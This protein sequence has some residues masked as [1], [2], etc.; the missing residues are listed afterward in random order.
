MQNS[1]GKKQKK[2]KQQIIMSGEVK[3]RK[4][5]ILA[6]ELREQIRC[7][8]L[9][10][11]D[12]LPTLAVVSLKS[13]MTSP[14]IIRAHS[15]LEREGLIYRQ[16]GNGTFVAAEAVRRLRG[17]PLAETIVVLTPFG[18]ALSR[19]DRA[20]GWANFTT[21]GILEEIHNKCRHAI[22]L[23]PD[24]VQNKDIEWLVAQQPLGVILDDNY[25]SDLDHLRF[26]TELFTQAAIPVAALG[27]MPFWTQCDRVESD[28]ARGAYELTRWL[29][30]QGRRRIL[31]LCPPGPHLDW[32]AKRLAGY[33]QAME[34]A[35]LA[36]LPPVTGP[37]LPL[38]ATT[39]ENFEQ[40]CRR[41]AAVLI[42]SLTGPTPCDALMAPS[43]GPAFYYAAACRLFGKQPNRDVLL[44]GY[45]N[46]W[47][48]SP[49]R[50]WEPVVPAVTVDKHNSKIGKA[51]VT[52]LN[53]RSAGACPAEPQLRV[54]A[55]D[56]VPTAAAAPSYFAPPA[57][58][59]QEKL[60]KAAAVSPVLV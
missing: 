1:S 21:A 29:L 7:G 59:P 31:P 9:K 56:L 32:V 37:A 35:G 40:D 24:T 13:G 44:T 15:L 4:F 26:I 34:E 6:T 36:P 14:T 8:H 27:N 20:P 60:P 33:V 45:D 12:R 51:L 16:R 49:E 48:E 38:N 50:Q 11:G 18:M 39:Q 19:G 30:A 42:E 46:Y 3:P 54:I 2:E 23:H 47:Q 43:D 53:E 5:E 22:I 41:C 10:P 17:G 57:D 28:H 52:L 55:P 58:L 25:S